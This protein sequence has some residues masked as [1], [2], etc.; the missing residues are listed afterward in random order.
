MQRLICIVVLLVSLLWTTQAL[1]LRI[2]DVAPDFTV[3]ST[4]GEITLSKALEKGP[5]V[6]ALYPHNFTA[7]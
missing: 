1:A 5:V 3:M 7:R 4:R 6:L 2:G